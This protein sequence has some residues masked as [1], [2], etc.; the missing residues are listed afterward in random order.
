VITPGVDGIF[1]D[2][3][4]QPGARRSRVVGP[5]GD[6]LKVAV[7]APAVSGRANQAL[8]EALAAVFDVPVRDISLTSGHGSRRKRVFVRG[9]DVQ[10]AQK[11]IEA[12]L[13]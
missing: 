4:V 13:D 5:H 12:S 9:I 10:L 11:R 6:A 1:I 2:L 7:S 3:Q 8:L